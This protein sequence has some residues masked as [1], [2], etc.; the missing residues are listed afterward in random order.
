MIYRATHTTMYMYS[1]PVSICHSEVHLCPREH[2]SQILF[3]HELTIAPEPD[4]TESRRDYFGNEV[5]YFSIHSPH[6]TLT[7]TSRSVVEVEETEPPEATLSPKWETVREQLG[8]G[9]T[10]EQLDVAAFVYGSPQAPLAAAYADY[11]R[12]CFPEGRP[13]LAAVAELT[14]KICREFEY[15]PRATSVTTPVDEVLEKRKGVCQD[16]AHLM[17]AC[18]RSLGLPARYVSG[19]LRSGEKTVGAEASHAWVSV[20]C[21]VFGWQDFDPTNNV[22]PQGQH[23]TLAWGREYQDVTPVKGV[24][25]GGGEQIISVS[26]EVVPATVAG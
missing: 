18:L 11:A 19:Y 23:V 22:R 9:V 2:P 8:E 14:S 24:A 15:D 26:V 10:G 16:F 17:I 13:F 6:E 25:L 12:P 5:T 20:H 21:P 4:F 7:I 3:E 1:D